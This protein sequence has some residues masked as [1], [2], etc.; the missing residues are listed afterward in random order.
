LVQLNDQPTAGAIE[1]SDRVV[2]FADLLGF[3]ALTEANPLDFRMLR[4][5]SRFPRLED[6]EEMM[7]HKNPLTAAFSTFH[8]SVKSAISLAEMEHPFTAITFPDSVLIFLNAPFLKGREIVSQFAAQDISEA[9]NIEVGRVPET[10]NVPSCEQQN[11]ILQ[12]RSPPEQVLGPDHR[13]MPFFQR[14]ERSRR[15]CVGLPM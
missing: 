4:A 10:S 8:S 15:L 11:A 3:A 5:H 14:F 6:L 9:V 7:T 13:N 1:S 12:F 2:L